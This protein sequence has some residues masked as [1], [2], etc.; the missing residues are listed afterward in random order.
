MLVQLLSSTFAGNLGELALVLLC[1]SGSNIALLLCICRNGVAHNFILDCKSSLSY[2][3]YYSC[4]IFLYLVIFLQDYQAQCN[5][6]GGR[7]YQSESVVSWI[8]QVGYTAKLLITINSTE[9]I[10]LFANNVDSMLLF[11]NLTVHL[12]LC[13]KF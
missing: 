6:P 1:T 12:Q 11:E 13:C 5:K 8:A 9:H 7:K 10:T 3:C 4:L 2:R